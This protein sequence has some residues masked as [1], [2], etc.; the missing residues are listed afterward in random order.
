MGLF[1]G[2]R[3]SAAVTASGAGDVFSPGRSVSTGE[4]THLAP[5]FGAYRSIIDY[6]STMPVVFYQ[7]GTGR[8]RERI[9]WP[10][11]ANRVDAE[12]GLGNWIGQMLYGIVSR[13]NAV[14]RAESVDSW[15]RPTMIS[16]AKDWSFSDLGTSDQGDDR[17]WL[18]GGSMPNRLVA[19]VPWIVPNGRR[20]GLSPIEHFAAIIRAGLSAQEY[21]DVARGGGLPPAHL[22]NVAQVLDDQ[23]ATHARERATRSFA[24]GKPFVTGKDWDLTLMAIPPNQAQFVETLK[25]SANQIAA[26]YGIDPREIGGSASESL[27][28]TNDESRAL[29]RAHNMR[30]YLR[31]IESAVSRWL[32]PGQF[33]RFDIE[34]TIR[35]DSKTST[36][37]I[38]SKIADGRMSVNEARELEDKKPVDG[39]DFHNVPRPAERPSPEGDLAPTA[40]DAAETIQKIYLGVDKMITADEARAIANRVGAE[41]NGTFTPPGVPNNQNGDT[42]GQP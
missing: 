11:L 15:G 34:S 38:G 39:G 18:D 25:L 22:K 26:I 9:Q 2:E 36:E 14:G 13:G 32:P 10:E 1:F 17:W 5:V 40:R 19:H 42:H 30:P 37:I 8:T 3:R 23:A 27:T 31:R 29:N 12:M 24:T 21:A 6:G 16:W 7:R 20:L 35:V 41:L 4:A 28:Y 33:M